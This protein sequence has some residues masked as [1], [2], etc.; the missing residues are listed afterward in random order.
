MTYLMYDLSRATEQVR[1]GAHL[2]PHCVNPDIL[3]GCIRTLNWCLQQIAPERLS[4]T[5]NIPNDPLNNPPH[6]GDGH[7]THG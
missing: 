5:L 4:E 1:C 3:L 2:E 7:A 6:K